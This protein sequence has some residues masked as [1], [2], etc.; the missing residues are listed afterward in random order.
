MKNIIATG[1]NRFLQCDPE[2]VDELQKIDGKVINI[3]IK[4]LDKTICLRVSDR[5]LENIEEDITPDVEL[6][7]SMRVLPGY[8][9]GADRNQQIKN[10]D[11]EVIGDTHVAS[12]FHNVL[13]T[14][15]I[16]WEEILAARVGDTAAH[17]I[18]FGAKKVKG[19]LRTVRENVQMD[20]R[21]YL[22]DNL[23]VAVTQIE[24][25][26]FIQNVDSLRAQVDRLEARIN[27]LQ[28]SSQER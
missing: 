20:T 27:R 9:L 22:Q 19:F 2:R 11:I 24:V 28:A 15:E 4:E 16:D 10:G 18:G 6:I 23:Q 25:D 1:L 8:L 13:S 17:Q 7:V 12:V 21:D 14:V 26:T 5:Q 3:K